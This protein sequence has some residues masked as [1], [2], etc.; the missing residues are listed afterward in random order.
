M[1]R[2]RC[3]VGLLDVVLT[4]VVLLAVAVFILLF[5]RRRAE[6]IEHDLRH[7]LDVGSGEAERRPPEG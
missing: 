1:R 4:L 5:E 3:I 7:Q 2:R 6:E